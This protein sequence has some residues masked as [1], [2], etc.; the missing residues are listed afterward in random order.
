M[1]SSKVGPLIKRQDQ[2]RN[3]VQATNFQSRE[4]SQ[5][6][7][8]QEDEELDENERKRRQAQKIMDL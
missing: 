5:E 7:S 8:F 6:S 4:R 1:L 3:S 2:M